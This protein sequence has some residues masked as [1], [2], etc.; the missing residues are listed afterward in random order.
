MVTVAIF[1]LYLSNHVVRAASI[2]LA[3]CFILF[4]MFLDLKPSRKKIITPRRFKIAVLHLVILGGPLILNGF[5]A[6]ARS[7]FD[8]MYLYNQ[9]QNHD[10]GVYSLALQLSSVIIIICTSLSIAIQPH[11]F[12]GLKEN[13]INHEY[14]NRIA[15][16]LIPICFV[17]YVVSLLIPEWIYAY[18]L[19]GGFDGIDYYISLFCLGLGPTLF[20]VV[21]SPYLWYYRKNMSIAISN[22]LSA[23]IHI[24]SLYFLVAEYGLPGAPYATILSTFSLSIFNYMV[25]LNMKGKSSL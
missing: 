5:S 10:L 20:Y 12:Q 23:L 24:F 14:I 17:P 21:I 6:F 4:F 7:Q 2:L 25:F 1:E 3:N 9:I 16:L 13:K 11:Y 18:V 15:I 22:V 8:R 19:G